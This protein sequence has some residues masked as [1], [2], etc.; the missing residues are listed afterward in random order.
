VLVDMTF[1]R[2]VEVTIVQ[3]IGVAAVTHGWVATAWAVLMRN[4]RNGWGP[5]KSSWDSV[6]SVFKIHGRRGA[7]LCGDV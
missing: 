4:G 1:V 5:S 6:L 3:V 2:V 7:A